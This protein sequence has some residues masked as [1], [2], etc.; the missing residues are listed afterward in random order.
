M[1]ARSLVAPASGRV[2][3]AA[4]CVAA[5]GLLC[6]GLAA[7]GDEPVADDGKPAGT[8][9]AA[10]PP[11]PA[12]A[13]SGSAAPKGAAPGA[14]PSR[15]FSERDFAESEQSRDPFRSFA[16][17]FLSQAQTRVTLQRRVLVDRYALE[18]LKLIGI[19]KGSPSRALLT[20][21][22]GLG[23]VVKVGD[24][25]ARAELVHAGGPTGSDV[26]VNWRVDRIRDGDVVLVREDPSHPD[27]PATTRVIS[28]RTQEEAVGLRRGG[29]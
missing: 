5:L 9:G 16:G 1:P 19:V 22:T 29:H 26:A 28:L 25:V 13:P 17:V 6:V 15:E 24:F 18:E 8:P 3:R 20:D 2:A 27:I 10:E 21:P 14:P 12:A 23:W 4:L 7:C 11:K